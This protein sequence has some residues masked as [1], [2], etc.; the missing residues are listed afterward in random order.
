MNERE[1]AVANSA[2]TNLFDV[3]QTGVQGWADREVAQEETRRAEILG[4]DASALSGPNAVEK[5]RFD[6]GTI[7]AVSAVAL[8][9]VLL[10]VLLKR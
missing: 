5:K 4:P 1:F 7:M 9:G 10:L 8:G 6:T 2:G 3:L